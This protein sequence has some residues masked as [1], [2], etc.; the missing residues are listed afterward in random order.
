MEKQDGGFRLIP[1]LPV[2][3]VDAIDGYRLV[4]DSGRLCGVG[5]GDGSCKRAC[6]GDAI[7]DFP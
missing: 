4:A 3:D 7:H 2:G 1:R 6:G 5:D